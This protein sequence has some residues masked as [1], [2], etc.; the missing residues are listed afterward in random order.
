MYPIGRGPRGE[1]LARRAVRYLQASNDRRAGSLL[2]VKPKQGPRLLPF[3]L[4]PTHPSLMAPFGLSRVCYCL[5]LNLY[6]YLYLLMVVVCM[7]YMCVD[8]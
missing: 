6:M 7:L 4:P 2:C 5:L 3:R 8:R 1:R